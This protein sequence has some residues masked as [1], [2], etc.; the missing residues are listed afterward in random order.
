[1]NLI[2]EYVKLHTERT[3]APVSY[4]TALISSHIGYILGRGSVH[5]YASPIRHNF[6]IMLVGDAGRTRK[7][8]SMNILNRI[9]PHDVLPP[10]FTPEAFIGNLSNNP[11]GMLEMDEVSSML[12]KSAN[13][14]SYMSGMIE[15]FNK[16]YSWERGEYRRTT[17]TSGLIRVKNPYL[18]VRMA[19][20]EE[21]LKESMSEEMLAGGF[22][23]RTLMVVE[24]PLGW[25]ER[26]YEDEVSGDDVITLLDLCKRI[27]G[28]INFRFSPSARQLFNRYDKELYDNFSHP[29]ISRA[30]DYIIKLSDVREV[31]GLAC[32]GSDIGETVTVGEDSVNWAYKFIK[33]TVLRTQ[34]TLGDI[35]VSGIV[36]KTRKLL[37]EKSPCN[38]K[39]ILQYGHM[40]S[41]D[42]TR[43]LHTELER[44]WI[45]EVYDGKRK[46]YCCNDAVHRGR[47]DGCKYSGSCN[48]G[49][50]E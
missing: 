8:I 7:S 37:R 29:S 31:S 16:L 19:L 47:C 6:Y 9:I 46:M 24:S 25:K 32:N 33:S 44:G 15:I 36:R 23:S 45:W 42:L 18:S 26:K 3:D 12:K 20:T 48:R 40:M 14:N 28:N 1:M 13:K 39:T 2:D 38:R 41:T 5:S 50:V 43:I 27:P 11:S 49:M 35:E 22:V 4:A 34:E 30:G 17:R 21:A 10:E